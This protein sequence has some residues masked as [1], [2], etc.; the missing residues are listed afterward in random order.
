VR[1]SLLTAALLVLAWL[2]WMLRDLVI[3]IGFAA[4]FAYALDPVVSW[5]ERIRGLRGRTIPRGLAAGFTIVLL[6]VILGTTIAVAV[7]RLAQQFVRF[8]A[9]VPGVLAR[10]DQDLRV[11]VAAHP[12][13][14]FGGSPN[15][16]QGGNA[17]AI[18]GA[19]GGGVK[20]LAGS[21]LGNLGGLA[22]LV[23]LPLFAF[24]MLADAKRARSSVLAEAPRARREQGE[25]ILDALD[26]ALRAYVRG[27]ALVCLAMGATVGVVLALMGFPVAALLG[28]GVGLAEIVPI[29]GFWIAAAA[30]ALEGYSKSPGFAVAGVVSY[31]VVNNLMNTFVSPRLLGRQVKLHPFVVNVAVIGGGMLLGPG[32]A[33]LALPAAAIAK[34]LL[35]EF[36]P[37]S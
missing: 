32:G 20:S 28:V 10:L 24:Y 7:P 2:T 34:S 35:D 12:W 17:K 15:G 8:A 9:A 13:A 1:Q 37:R 31:I 23:L 4:V 14:G 30:I 6:A 21:A 25:R 19:I 33:I 18:L 29:L 3:L 16:D 5:L 27:Q 26:R 36:G 22:R 11:F